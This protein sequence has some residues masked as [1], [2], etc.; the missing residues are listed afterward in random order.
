MHRYT[1]FTILGAIVSNVLGWQSGVVPQAPS[2]TRCQATS[3]GLIV[4][5]ETVVD[6]DY[7]ELQLASSAS[8][9]MFA[10]IST[11]NTKAL[12]SDILPNTTYWLRVRAHAAG[13][14]SLGPGTWGSASVAHECTAPSVTF[15]SAPHNSGIGT[16][17]LETMRESEFTYDIDYLMNHNAGDIVGDTAFLTGESRKANQTS[18]LNVSFYNATFALFC[19]EVLQVHVPNTITTGGSDHFA[20]YVSCNN[21]GNP[22]D[23]QC[24]C[25]NWI[26]RVI[27]GLDPNMSCQTRKGT[28]CTPKGWLSDCTCNCTQESLSFSQK[29]TG[30]MPVKVREVGKAMGVWYS[31]P[32]RAECLEN[33]HVGMLHP[34]GSQCTW[35]R[36]VDFRVARGWQ[37][38]AN[39][40][41]MN[42]TNTSHK[43]TPAEI[44]TQNV[45][46]VR[47]TLNA[48]PLKP[49]T[50]GNDAVLLV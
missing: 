33:E 1:L 19:V 48:A 41:Y 27:G 23:P 49:W 8:G 36:R 5:W 24:G 29:Y 11:A 28:H 37:V 42:N 40:W 14:P 10:A 31:F 47:R 30:M 45:A 50:C 25:D 21:N 34:D 43:P 2:I 20:D 44:V 13:S 16:Y 9:Q 32:S 4:N 3:E 6:A 15:R 39:G 46:A 7:Y 18:F 22:R 38:L 17:F 26:D 35:K 12:L